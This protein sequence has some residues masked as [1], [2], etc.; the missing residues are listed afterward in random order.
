MVEA[1]EAAGDQ[2]AERGAWDEALA[3]YER[4]V[5]QSVLTTSIALK[6]QDVVV[7]LQQW[8]RAETVWRDCCRRYPGSWRLRCFLIEILLRQSAYSAAMDEI[9]AAMA[10]FGVDEGLLAAALSVRQR[11]GR[12][13]ARRRAI[14]FRSA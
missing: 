6:Y 8:G 12:L 10:E 2:H 7:R 3:S 5:L 1:E 11:S 9:E 14:A 4:G 13:R